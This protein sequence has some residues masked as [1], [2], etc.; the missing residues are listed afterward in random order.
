MRRAAGERQRR[1]DKWGEEKEER[2]G[3]RGKGRVSGK[4]GRRVDRLM[5]AQY[6]NS[7]LHFHI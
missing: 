2:K 5:S 4:Y 1:G 3:G 6:E 7:F